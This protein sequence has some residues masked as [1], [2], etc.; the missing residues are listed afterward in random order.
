MSRLEVVKTGKLWIGGKWPRSESGATFPVTNPEGE[1]VAR[2]ASASRKDS[3]DAVEAARSGLGKWRDSTAMLRGQVMYRAAEMLEGRAAELTEALQF[4]GAGAAA[5]RQEVDASIDRMVM[6]A[7]WCDKIHQVLGC[8]NSVAGPYHCFTIPQ[9][10]GV[11]VAFSPAEPALLSLV[12]LVGA[13][14]SIGNSVVAVAPPQA[15]LAAVLLGEV[16][17]VSDVPAGAVNILTGNQKDLVEPLGGHRE[18]A[19]VVSGG[20]SKASRVAVRMAAADGIRRVHAV[21]WT[22]SAWEDDEETCS[23]WFL[24]QFVEFKTLWHPAAS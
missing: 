9:P 13:A 15:G 7:G 2:C 8:Q 4:G 20:L 21:P 10:C 14:M 22:G 6:L 11:V 16:L 1:V 17:A 24:E 18:V 12:T 19:V 3:R 5:A 23:P